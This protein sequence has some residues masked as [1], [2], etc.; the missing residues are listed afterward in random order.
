MT[1]PLCCSLCRTA[2]DDATQENC[3]NKLQHFCFIDE[4]NL[5]KVKG[6]NEVHPAQYPLR[7][8]YVPNVYSH[9]KWVLPQATEIFVVV[10]CVTSFERN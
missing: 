2:A 6:M 4:T 1:E 10:F 9:A 5:F 8:V 7:G 3:A